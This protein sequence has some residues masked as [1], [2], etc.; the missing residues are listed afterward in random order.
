MENRVSPF[1]PR[2]CAF[3]RSE[4]G[5][6]AS[7]LPN[8]PQYFAVGEDPPRWWSMRI[9]SVPECAPRDVEHGVVVMILERGE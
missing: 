1:A 4:S 6:L 7:Y 5:L 8:D 3:F 2:K 9:F